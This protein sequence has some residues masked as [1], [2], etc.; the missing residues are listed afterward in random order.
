M[1]I[2]SVPLIQVMYVKSNQSNFYIDELLMLKID[3]SDFYSLA[4]VTQNI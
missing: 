1:V 2:S 4:Y 3:E